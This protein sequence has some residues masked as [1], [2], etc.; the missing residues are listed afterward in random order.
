MSG[1]SPNLRGILLMLAATA[2]FTI[3]DTMLKL[4]TVDLP[5]F[6]AVFLRSL[7]ICIIGWPMMAISGDLRSAGRM[8]DGRVMFRNLF[9]LIAVFGFMLGLAYAPIADLTAISQLSPMLLLIGAVW[10]FGEKMSRLQLSL[11]FVA[12]AGALLVAQPGGSGFAPF[13]LFGFWNAGCVAIRDLLGRRIGRDVPGLVVAIGSGFVVLIGTGVATMLFETWVWPSVAACALIAGSAV[14]VVLGHWLIFSSF[15]AAPVSIV[16][17]FCYASTI[18]ALISGVL[19]FG[20]VPN[21]LSMAG[22][23]LIVGSGVVVVAVERWATRSAV[24]P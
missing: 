8:A 12:F 4:V 3:N 10:F 24:M 11:V 14:F 13:A 6:E 7:A 16:A 23:A 17:P 5:P 21:A 19:V 9:E 1:L 22:M 2:A 20:S 18:W 15:R